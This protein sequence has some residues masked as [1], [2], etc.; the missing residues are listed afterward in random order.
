ML[1]AVFVDRLR[2]AATI[3]T[4]I[5]TAAAVLGNCSFNLSNNIALDNVMTQMSLIPSCN[6]NFVPLS[7]ESTSIS[8]TESLFS[9]LL[10]SAVVPIKINSIC[11]MRLCFT[12]SVYIYRRF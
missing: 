4:A 2:S 1:S 11:T 9:S 5:D 6:L 8:K 12:F 10:S 7:V 3:G